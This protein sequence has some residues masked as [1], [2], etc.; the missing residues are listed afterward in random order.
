MTSRRVQAIRA[1]ARAVRPT[2]APLRLA[3]I[4]LAV[5][6]AAIG[7][8]VAAHHPLFPMIAAALFAI[9]IAVVAR[10]PR[11][12][13]FAVP[14]LLPVLGFA[15]WTGWI[16]FEEFD[17]L[18]LGAVAGGYLRIAMDS[19]SAPSAVHSSAR[20]PW[21]LAAAFGVWSVVALYRG[22]VG[23]GAAA[24]GWFDG[25]YDPLNSVRVFKG[26][27]FAM[28][29]WPLAVRAERHAPAT[30]D[31]AGAGMATGCAL[32][33]L[34]VVWERIAFPGF[35]DFSSDY[36]VTG[37]FWEMHVGGAALDG[38]LALTFPFVVRD[39]LCARSRPRM[40]LSVA[41]L[42]L[43]GYACLVTFSRGLYAG[44]FVAAAA[45]VFLLRLGKQG[46]DAENAPPIRLT[47]VVALVAVTLVATWLSFSR[48]GYR[49]VAAILGVVAL[50]LAL[51]PELRKARVS[52]WLPAA[53]ASACGAAVAVFAAMHVLKGAYALYALLFG[54]CAALAWRCRQAGDGT[55]TSAATAAFFALVIAAVGVAWWWGG[56]G[57]ASD[58]IAALTLFG[59]MIG[60]SAASSKPLWP[61]DLRTGARVFATVIL[62]SGAVVVFS[63]G[64]YMESRFATSRSDFETRIAH[65]RQV[66]ELL[67]FPSEWVA[68]AGLGRLPAR[69]FYDAHVADSPGSYAIGRDD[70]ARFLVVAGGRHL[71]GFGE[72]LR[73]SQRVDSVAGHGVRARVVARAP[74]NARLEISI[75]EKHLLYSTECVAAVEQVKPTYPAWQELTANLDG[76]QFSGA[77]PLPRPMVFSLALDSEGTKLE[78]ASVSAIRDDGVSLIEN[79]D[80]SSGMARWF[81]T[82]DHDHLPWHAKNLFLNVLFDQGIVGLAL[83]TALI[84][85]T[86]ARLVGASRARSAAPFFAASLIGFVV[87]GLFDSLIDVARIAF[88]F[89]FVVFVS[90]TISAGSRARKR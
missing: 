49:A 70:G 13:I 54:A 4:P 37:T 21:L 23:A 3:A 60:A 62:L 58:S 29:L 61:G 57:A 88:L 68:G 89:Y 10:W 24:P 35:F 40:L 18:A 26:F 41:V 74:R 73:I 7:A 30:I 2:V 51:A 85:A 67:R 45:L 64:A 56:A 76:R 27:A 82:S 11:S 12:W 42:L 90:L 75:C 44:L 78:V 34:V 33:S 66:G 81:F 19:S 39:C 69:Y 28:L 84:V 65:W 8:F 16:A 43:C 20:I 86:L 46:G 52:L 47:G 1:D 17:L 63:A 71:H 5:V 59:A 79:G 22:Y 80:L 14:A 53:I 55:G 36:R 87:V 9:W 83:F 32:A 38:F 6:C 15:T 25:Y 48:G 72:L 77:G 31:V 50:A